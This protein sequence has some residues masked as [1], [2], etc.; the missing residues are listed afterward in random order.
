MGCGLGQ[1]F[2]SSFLFTTASR[3]ALVSAQPLSIMIKRSERE[4]D[5]FSPTIVEV[6]TRGAVPLIP[7][8]LG[9]VILQY[10]CRLDTGWTR[11]RSEFESR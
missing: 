3:L 4:V 7:R 9:T 8:T 10:A 6:N 1:S 11:E 2:F 5:Q